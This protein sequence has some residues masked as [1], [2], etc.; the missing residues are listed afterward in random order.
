MAC[1]STEDNKGMGFVTHSLTGMGSQPRSA[2]W[3]KKLES[4]MK[5]KKAGLFWHAMTS[6]VPDIAHGAKKAQ[7]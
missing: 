6:A 7:L 1:L 3:I 4:E 2:Y 5:E